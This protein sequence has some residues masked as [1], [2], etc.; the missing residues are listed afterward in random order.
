MAYEFRNIIIFSNNDQAK[1]DSRL[2]S[3]LGETIFYNIKISY[4]NRFN[5]LKDAIIKSVSEEPI[6]FLE[7]LNQFEVESMLTVI[8]LL[9]RFRLVI[10]VPENKPDI[11]GI[12]RKL[13]PKLM[14]TDW[15]D[16]E[17]THLLLQSFLISK[18]NSD[19]SEADRGADLKMDLSAVEQREMEVSQDAE[20]KPIPRGTETILLVDDDESVRDISRQVL[21]KFGYTVMT[22]SNGEEAVETYANQRSIIDL[23]VMDLGMPGMGGHACFQEI[24]RLDPASK[25]LIASGYPSSEQVKQTMETGAMGYVSKPYQLD[26][27]LNKVREALDETHQ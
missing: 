24:I 17:R 4:H 8:D 25:V 7:L 16:D 14:I 18:K 27:L 20:H 15:P 13:R 26:Y 5:S 10:K 21:M 2:F 11:T 1:I 6:I 19:G 22:A 9:S 3:L 23:V 12:A